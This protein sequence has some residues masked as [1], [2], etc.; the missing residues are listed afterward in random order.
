MNN[1]NGRRKKRRVILIAAL[2]VIC[3]IY[4]HNTNIFLPKPTEYKWMAHR[5]VHQTFDESMTTDSSNT[6]AMIGPPTHEYLEN[7][8]SSMEAAFAYGA[9]IVEFDIKMTRDEQFA[10]FHDSTLVYRTDVAGEVGEYTMEELKRLDIGYGYTFDGGSTYPFRGKH[11]GSMPELGEVLGTFPEKEF[12]IHFKDGNLRSAE[13]L[14][15]RIA[16][17]N[18]ECARRIYFYGNDDL[19]RYL[20][21][22]NPEYKVFSRETM[23]SGLLQYVGIGWT[24]MV[25]DKLKNRILLLPSDY[26]PFLWGF[27]QKFVERMESAGSIVIL[28]NGDGSPAAGFDTKE[29]LREIPG[30]YGG[31]VWTNRVESFASYD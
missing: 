16:G 21:E 17:W 9:G 11:M 5:G 18:A 30:G 27:P 6:A 4:F 3:F 8:I 2:A 20:L 28:A 13:V 31:Y 12:L 23:L 29:E 24:G 19:I 15:E 26:A 10:V 14:S 25:P 22:H 7:T 1:K